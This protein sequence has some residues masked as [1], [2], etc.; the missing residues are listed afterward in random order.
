MPENLGSILLTV[1]KTQNDQSAMSTSLCADLEV[2]T[3]VFSQF[4]PAFAENLR[5]AL[6]ANRQRYT[7]EIE[8]RA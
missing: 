1:V 5:K 6:A 3:L 2:L 8:R 4:A 7:E